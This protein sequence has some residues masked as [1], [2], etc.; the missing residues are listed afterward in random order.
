M[1]CSGLLFVLTLLAKMAVA[2]SPVLFPELQ[3]EFPI[4]L[5]KPNGAAHLAS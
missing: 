5:T 3:G 1:R 4:F 2:D